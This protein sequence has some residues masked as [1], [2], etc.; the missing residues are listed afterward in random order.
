MTSS[1]SEAPTGVTTH[2]EVI[3]QTELDTPHGIAYVKAVKITYSLSPEVEK[4]KLL[5]DIMGIM[6]QMK[7]CFE[8]IKGERESSPL[9]KAFE[10]GFGA[11]DK[12]F[13]HFAQ[14][15]DKASGEDVQKAVKVFGLI[16]EDEEE[17]EDALEAFFEMEAQLGSF[18][19]FYLGRSEFESTR[20]SITSDAEDVDSGTVDYKVVY[21]MRS[22]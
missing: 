21:G 12:A 4:E 9:L 14:E 1:I 16:F 19:S 22:R 8:K 6:E 15:V 11:V 3:R 10:K 2:E 17:K 20:L 5:Q 13:N 18:Q 7:P